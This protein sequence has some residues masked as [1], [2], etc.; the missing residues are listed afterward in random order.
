M[1]GPLV[2]TGPSCGS[3]SDWSPAPSP[4]VPSSSRLPPSDVTMPEQSL[5]VVPN[6]FPAISVL[7]T[8]TVP[9]GLTASPPPCPPVL[10]FAIV[11]FFRL[12]VPPE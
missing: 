7:R 12:V 8:S 4:Q 10:L 5:G 1:V 11:S 9:A 3:T 6:R 2:S